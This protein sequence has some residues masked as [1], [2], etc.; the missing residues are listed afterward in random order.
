MANNTSSLGSD[1]RKMIKLFPTAIK[2]GDFDFTSISLKKAIFLLSI[3]M[4]MEMFMESLFALCDA[5]YVSQINAQAMAAVGFTEQMMIVIYSIAFGVAMAVTALVSRRIGEKDVDGANK[6][7][8]QSILIGVG[9]AA[10]FT[11]IGLT[12]SEELLE[13]IGASPEAI[14][15][16]AI[17]TKWL[18]GGNI[19]ILLLFIL[20]AVFRGAGD[21]SMAMRVLI[22]SNGLNLILDPFLI[23][24]WGIIEPMGVKGA[25]IATNIGRGTAVLVQLYI[26]FGGKSIIKLAGKYLRP[27]WATI[28]HILQVSAGG[29]GQF[30]VASASWIF[31]AS[32]MARFGDNVVAG[33][34]LAIRLLMFTILPAWGMSNAAATLVGQNLGAEKPERA[35]KAVW[36]TAKYAAIFLGVVSV[37]Y[38]VGAEFIL[39]FADDT[40]PEIVQCG[41]ACLRI[42]S[43]GYIFYAYGMIMAQAFNGAGD[44]G[45]PTRLNFIAF[46][47]CQIPLAW[48]L[49]EYTNLQDWSVY[50]AI[51]VSEILL[52]VLC[53]SVFK[54]GKWK[55]KRV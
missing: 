15:E 24:G 45:T 49:A 51:V 1:L 4:I 34:W 16:G 46:W 40:S 38:M 35:E 6:A 18:F 20:N 21:A 39:G 11:A 12:W 30:I 47:L 17:Y 14:A 36:K 28:R 50:I 29:A 53:V 5:I 52:T 9:L 26:L 54:K 2:G 31:L 10:V 23:F 32:I 19:V 27:N 25:A 44:T 33:Y 8:G 48:A 13:L 3:P 55:L 37:F 43:A 22:I 42:V 7:S 41:A